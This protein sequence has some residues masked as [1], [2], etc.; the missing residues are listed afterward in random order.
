M[1]LNI[2]VKFRNVVY[3]TLSQ[4]AAPKVAGVIVG[5]FEERAR[6]VLGRGHEGGEGSVDKKPLVR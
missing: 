5:A 3:A 1:S 6:K 4:A 2:E